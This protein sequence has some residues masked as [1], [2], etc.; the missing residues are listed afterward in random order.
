[1]QHTQ[2]DLFHPNYDARVQPFCRN[3]DP[4][5]SAEAAKKRNRSA[6]PEHFYALRHHLQH[7]DSDRNAGLAL[8]EAG[9]VADV[10]AGRRASRTIREDLNWIAIELGD[11]GK[12][13][14]VPNRGTTRSGQRNR[15]TEK[16]SD[17]LL[18][19]SI[20]TL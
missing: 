6:G 5:T 14:T 18:T 3:S 17:A 11:N 12:P 15:V 1:M 2:T 4:A 20:A 9:L 7:R 10:E 13:L 16:G 19:H 8:F